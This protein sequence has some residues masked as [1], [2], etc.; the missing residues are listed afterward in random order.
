M[1]TLNTFTIEWMDTCYRTHTEKVQAD[2][3]EEAE[4]KIKNLKRRIFLKIKKVMQ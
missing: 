3:K 2:T 4:M 1:N